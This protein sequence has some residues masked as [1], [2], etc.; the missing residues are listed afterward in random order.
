M[1]WDRFWTH[2]WFC[3]INMASEAEHIDLASSNQNLIDHLIHEN[4]FH[5]WLATVA[6]YKAIH[7]VEAV[8]ANKSALS[9]VQSR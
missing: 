3:N 1:R 6:F 9:F 7:V 8:F 5:D 2:G 4:A